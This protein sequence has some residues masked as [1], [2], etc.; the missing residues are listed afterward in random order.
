[1]NNEL[2]IRWPN[3][4]PGTLQ[5]SPNYQICNWHPSHFDVEVTLA[6]FILLALLNTFNINNK[7]DCKNKQTSWNLVLL[8]HHSCNEFIAAFPLW[9]FRPPP[10]LN[11]ARKKGQYTIITPFLH[12]KSI[13]QSTLLK[14]VALIV[15][16]LAI[17]SPLD[18]RWNWNLEML[19]FLRSALKTRSLSSLGENW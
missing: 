7:I 2:T 5:W 8:R 11:V 12:I 13:N 18:S 4:Q 19:I 10:S 1:M 17:Q 14:R 6:T 15:F 9:K 3:L 16:C